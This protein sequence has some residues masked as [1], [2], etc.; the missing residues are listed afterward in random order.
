MGRTVALDHLTFTIPA[1][2][3]AHQTPFR[4]L[5]QGAR[6]LAQI[7][8]Y[9]VA[10]DPEPKG[11]H[12]YTW[13]CPVIDT[14][15]GNRVGWL[16]AGGNGG[17]IYCS[18]DGSGCPVV[19]PGRAAEVIDDLG[20]RITRV[21]LCVDDYEGK[22]TPFDVRAAYQAGEFKKRG[23]NPS[24]SMAGPWDDPDRW[25]E[26]LT[27]YVGK[28]GAQLRFRCYH[29]GREQGD[30]ASDWVR[31]EIEMR[32]T[33]RD[34]SSDVLRDMLSA[35]V[36]AYPWLEWAAAEEDTVSISFLRREKTRI[37]LRFLMHHA[38]LSYGK[39]LNA[40]S[41]LGVN[42]ADAFKS[43]T[44]SGMPDRIDPRYFFREGQLMETGGV[45]SYV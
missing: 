42:P 1:P 40:I 10:L 44:R 43:L 13:T 27:Y 12:G 39:L 4:A 38:R 16:A 17:S 3:G 37:Q 29:K 18:I 2:G 9:L 6:A 21:D 11:L 14:Q 28:R 22:R 34:I 15:T 31:H 32:R 19:D 25:G 24:M 8:D 20:A 36:S 41:L 35:F 30:Q 7:S 5:A 23:Q 26:G 45:C 33:D